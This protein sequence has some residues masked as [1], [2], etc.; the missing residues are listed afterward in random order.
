MHSNE[1]MAE[2]AA[3]Q[4]RHDASLMRYPHV[5]GTGIGYRRRDGQTTEELCLVV[6]VN[7]KLERSELP[8]HAILPRELDGAPVDVV[9]TGAFAV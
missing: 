3:I 4:A 6:M 2:I 9:D 5:V 8:A 7:Q 1:R